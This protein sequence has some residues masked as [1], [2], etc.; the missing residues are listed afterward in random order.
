MTRQTCRR[1]ILS[2]VLAVISSVDARADVKLHPLFTDHM[3]LQRAQSIP[4]WGTADPGEA[5]SIRLQRRTPEWIE[6][7]VAQ[8]VADQK[9]EWK[10]SLPLPFTY[11]PYTLTI[12]GK[13]K[14]TLDDVLIGEVWICSGQSNM[15][16]KLS[17]SY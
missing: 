10:S 12:E 17:Q 11:G 1:W 7:N 13:N 5:V 6:S 9:G 14:L 4:I 8:A 15:E 16:W 3:V 2:T